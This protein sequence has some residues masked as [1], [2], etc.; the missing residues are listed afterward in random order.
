MPLAE[1]AYEK[2]KIDRGYNHRTLYVNVGD[3]VIREKPV[4]DRMRDLF[5]GGRG[6]DL[7]LLWNSLPHDRIVSW[8]DPLNEIV[9]ASGPLGGTAVYPGSG[10][11]IALGISP[12]TDQV[13]D[14]NVGGYFGPF[15][16]FAGFDAIEVQGKAVRD[17][18][19]VIGTA[20]GIENFRKANT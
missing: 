20:Q 2:G 10:K 15:L 1:Y 9:L 14:S 18:L 13:V 12:L 11:S 19:V 6:F 8:D 5:I 4:D 7:W 3:K 17:V 16:K